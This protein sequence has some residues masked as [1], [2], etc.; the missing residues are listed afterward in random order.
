[1]HVRVINVYNSDILHSL[2]RCIRVDDTH[3]HST[4]KVCIV[5][6]TPFQNLTHTYIRSGTLKTN[7]TTL[8]RGVH[9]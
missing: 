6:Y 7:N 1:M 8:L 9:P 5:R 3:T 2:E 4:P